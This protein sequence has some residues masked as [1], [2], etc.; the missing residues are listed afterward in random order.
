MMNSN[1][2]LIE[3]LSTQKEQYDRAVQAQEALWLGRGGTPLLLHCALNEQEQQAYPA[4]HYLEIHHDVDKMLANGL[5]EA[6]T[7]MKGGREAVPS[8]R[9]NM[10]CGIVAAWFGI[11]PELFEDKQPW[12]TKHLPKGLLMDMSADDLVITP[13]FRMALDHMAF[14]ARQL[15]GSGVRVFPVDIQGAFDTAHLVYGDDIFYQLY[16][17]PEFVHHLMDLSCTATERAFDACLELIPDSD[18][19]IAHYNSYAMPRAKGG[20]KLSEDTSTLLSQAHIEEFVAPYIHRLLRHAG[21]GYVHYC[22]RNDHLYRCIMAEPLCHGLNFGNPE[23]HNMEQVLR[24]CAATGRIY[25]GILPRNGHESW[26]AY[27][28]RL[29]GASFNKQIHVLLEIFCPEGERQGI[30]EAFDRAAE[31]VIQ[32]AV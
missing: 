19:T 12:V 3:R 25:Q 26:D 5:R 17:D 31:R 10:G 18:K 30:A 8:V 29:L 28:E 24:D 4:Y 21:G 9:A 32:S 2:S 13:E 16:D 15:Q 22:G 1:T 20:L 14:I 11:V 6:V 27:F 7:S 23:K